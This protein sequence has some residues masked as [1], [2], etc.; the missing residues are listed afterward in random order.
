MGIDVQ[1]ATTPGALDVATDPIGGTHYPVN[2]LAHG[3]AGEAS[4]VAVGNPLPV[5]LG[6][7]DL[8]VDAWGHPVMSQLFSIFHGMF[9]FD[10]PVKMWLTLEDGTEVTSPASSTGSSNG[11]LLVS[12][13]TLTNEVLVRSKRCPR[14]Q[15]NRG[16]RYSTAVWCPSKTAGG[17]AAYR[18]WGLFTDDNGVFFRLK[19]DGLLYVVVRSG[20]AED[21]QLADVSGV[22]GFDVEKGN[23]YDIQFQWRG[24]G[25]YAFFVNLQLV[26]TFSYLG[27]LTALSMENPALPAAY[28]CY[29][30][31]GDITL[32]AGCVDISSEGGDVAREQYGSAHGTESGNNTDY[33]IVSIYNP[34]L[35][36]GRVNTRNLRLARVSASSTAKCK[37]SVWKS[38]TAAAL[39]NESFSAIGDGSY[40]EVDTEATAMVTGNAVLLTMFNV[41]ANASEVSVNPNPDTI[42]FF[43]TDGDYVIVS[44]TGNVS[45]VDA[46]IEWGEEI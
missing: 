3:A 5:Q 16:H 15:P 27:T 22:S 30:D 35:I 26:Y 46:V 6:S 40:V 34:P 32:Y 7:G 33:P 41:E 18:D 17:P 10:I 1:P 20:G 43:V 44:Y 39:T 4:L 38:R 31:T 21:E 45:A 12:T 24:V 19:A 25:N 14:Y 9:T 11:A 36:G 23:V 2:K 13:D 42:D 37:I 8:Q 28:Y 29:K